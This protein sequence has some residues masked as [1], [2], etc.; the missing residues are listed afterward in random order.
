MRALYVSDECQNVHKLIDKGKKPFLDEDFAILLNNFEEFFQKFFEM[1]NNI[2]MNISNDIIKNY[3]K[4]RNK[5]NKIDS[6]FLREKLN[7]YNES[8]KQ[9][10]PNTGKESKDDN[11]LK[12]IYENE[13]I[14]KACCND[15][16]FIY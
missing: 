7:N 2:G 1:A 16:C 14:N 9:E 8:I 5:Y 3:E 13:S 10:K 4:E 12:I 6:R 11:T 15:K